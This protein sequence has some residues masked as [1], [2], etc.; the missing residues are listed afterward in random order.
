MKFDETT[1]PSSTL[2]DLAILDAAAGELQAVRSRRSASRSGS[3]RPRSSSAST[4][5]RRAGVITGYHAVLDARALGKDITAFI[6]VSIDHPRALAVVRAG[7][8]SAST[9]CSSATT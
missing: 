8:S 2:I 7:T 3:P 1:A 4:S 9:T 5:S 6:G